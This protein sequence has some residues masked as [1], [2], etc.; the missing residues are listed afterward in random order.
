[1]NPWPIVRADLRAMGV[2]ALL[3]VALIACA[4]A[5][6]IAVGAQ[7]RGLRQ[8]SARAADDFDLIIGAPGSQTQLVLTAVYLQ[9]EAL[10]LIDGAILNTLAADRR[11]AGA[12]PLAFGDIVQGHPVIGT[13]RDF[14]GRWGHALPTEGRL[15]DA[16][17]E[18]VIG[19]SVRLRIGEKVTPSHAVAGSGQD[20]AAHRH[21]GVA[22]TVV[23]RLPGMGSPWDNAI[24]IPVESVW[25]THGLGNGHATDPAKLG[26]PFDA[27]TIPGV[28]AIVVRPRAVPDAYTLRSQY[29]QGGT[30]ALFPAEVLVSLYRA[31]GDVR[32]VLVWAAALNNLL[33]FAAVLLL[34]ATLTSLRRRRYAVLRALGAPRGYILLV[35]WLGA[36]TLIAAGCLAGLAVGWAGAAGVSAWVASRTGLPAASGLGWSE[37][38]LAAALLGAG[39]ALALVPAM[40]AYR[41]S[42]SANLR[43]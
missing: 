15:F 22:Y 43:T 12:A 3:V 19:A 32:D 26:P 23:G 41:G 1:V 18:A 10:P 28:P 34:I 8:A 20:E 33:V 17:G 5:I 37:L 30:M 11:V 27:S 16:E 42:V 13:T 40:A 25:E 21:Q 24:L 38:R 35:T 9:P 2:A 6:G 29:R 36:T 39:G 4:V 7:E 14:A 31:V